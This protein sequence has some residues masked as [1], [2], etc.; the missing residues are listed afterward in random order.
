MSFDSCC[1]GGLRRGATAT[2]ARTGASF[3]VQ[4]R[5]ELLLR[6]G[7]QVHMRLCA[8]L[9]VFAAMDVISAA[10]ADGD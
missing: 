3:T 1:I 10:V 4:M 2:E 7:S 6:S 9:K 8:N 5:G